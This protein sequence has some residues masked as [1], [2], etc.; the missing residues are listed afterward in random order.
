MLILNGFSKERSRYCRKTSFLRIYGWILSPSIDRIV[1]LN[2]NNELLEVEVNI[3]REDIWQA[4]NK[5]GSPICAW[6][7]EGKLEKDL[8]IDDVY[9]EFYKDKKLLF[10][11]KIE[12][13]YNPEKEELLDSLIYKDLDD[14]KSD[15]KK[16]YKEFENNFENIKIYNF[17]EESYL[18]WFNNVNYTQY[19]NYCKEFEE[20]EILHSKAMQHYLSIEL[21]KIKKSDV[22]LDIAS[23]NSVCPDIINE[24]YSKNVYKQDIQY[25]EGIHGNKIGSNAESMPLDNNSIDKMALHCSFEHFEN[26]SDINFLNEA[27]RVLSSNG[28]VVITPFYM[29]ESK[30]ILTSPSIW[31]N[32]Y[33]MQDLP[34]FTRG[35]PIVINEEIKQRQ[36]KI[37]SVKAF[38]EEIVEPF[39]DKFFI[40]VYHIANVN[41]IDLGL[42]PKFTL[43]CTKI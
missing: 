36:E 24:F 22:Y 41:C 26:N 30:H 2:G 9:L 42:Y 28:K 43:V 35:Y 3:V 1:L 21:L 32:K 6:K 16:I 4:Y 5:I 15:M 33:M 8:D 37:Y 10:K 40:E 19:P 31:E 25:K 39:K 17:N 18:E 20:G 38:L 13:F 23:S 29:S 7:Y 14:I 12:L 11:Q 27:Y 34:K